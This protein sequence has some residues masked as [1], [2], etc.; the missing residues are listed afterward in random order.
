MPKGRIDRREA[1]ERVGDPGSVPAAQIEGRGIAG[2]GGR[3]RC[4]QRSTRLL[5]GRR[6]GEGISG[7]RGGCGRPGI[8]ARRVEVTVNH[9]D[10]SGNTLVVHQV[11]LSMSPGG[12][13]RYQNARK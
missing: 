3:R 8:V 12:V 6:P 2:V 5:A 10:A 13:R 1:G 9:G 4:P 11:T 7:D